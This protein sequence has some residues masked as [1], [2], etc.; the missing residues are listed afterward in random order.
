M[1]GRII[2]EEMTMKKYILSI[3]AFA[4]ALSCTKETPVENELTLGEGIPVT[5][6]V[7]S[8]EYG[9]DNEEVKITQSLNGNGYSYT[10]NAGDAFRLVAY[11]QIVA[12]GE[13]TRT[14]CGDFVTAAGG[15]KVTFS[16]TIPADMPDDYNE[17]WA[18]APAPKEGE[19]FV[20]ANSSH[21]TSK[22]KTIYRYL[23]TMDIAE[24]QDGTGFKYAHFCAA[25]S[26]SRKLSK[27]NGTWK[28]TGSPS[29]KMAEAMLHLGLNEGHEI[30]KIELSYEL[31]ESNAKKKTAFAGETLY[32]TNSTGTNSSVTYTFPSPILTIYDGGKVLPKDVFIA[33]RHQAAGAEGSKMHFKFYKAD[34]SYAVKKLSLKLTKE[35]TQS[36]SSLSS[37]N[38]Y[39]IGTLDTSNWS[40]YQPKLEIV[41]TKDDGFTAPEGAGYTEFP[42]AYLNSET[43]AGASKATYHLYAQLDED[44]KVS[45]PYKYVNKNTKFNIGVESATGVFVEN[46]FLGRNYL[47]EKR[48]YES[49]GYSFSFGKYYAFVPDG[50]SSSQAGWLRLI[51]SYF[52]TP[53]IP[54]YK[55]VKTRIVN[56]RVD[57]GKNDYSNKNPSFSIAKERPEDTGTG[58]TNYL[59]GA[60]NTRSSYVIKDE[61]TLCFTTAEIQAAVGSGKSFETYAVSEF[62]P[63]NTVAGTEYFIQ[64]GS[65]A[66]IREFVLTYEDSIPF[67]NITAQ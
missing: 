6:V 14:D 5:V 24:T 45:D 53:A 60:V 51:L 46:N 22:D 34:G 42:T 19:T 10:W 44:G 43:A 23:V 40:F 2:E 49:K 15:S 8:P 9:G 12:D 4:L 18:V 11:K 32:A 7:G 1:S 54:G 41:W 67:P 21:T 16:G 31:Y 3:A 57:Y 35:G 37:G 64:T 25:S 66:N 33:V 29:F 63:T 26:D 47:F 38:V 39:N 59:S 28:F 56:N 62:S 36:Y 27:E 58:S 52:S 55:L 17:Y 13:T 30:T 50:K 20:I 61:G 48:T 65:V